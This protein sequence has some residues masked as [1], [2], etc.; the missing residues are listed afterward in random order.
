M[1]TRDLS[2]FLSDVMPYVTTCPEPTAIYHLRNAAIDFCQRTRIW[3]HEEEF[4]LTESQDEVFCVP[5]DAAIHEIE[6]A[7]FNGS[8]LQALPYGN[9]NPQTSD[10]LPHYITQASPDTVKVY[11]FHEGSL[12]LQLFL[13]PSQDAETVPGFL[14]D[15]HKLTIAYGALAEILMLPLPVANPGLAADFRQRF[16]SAVNARFRANIR[17]QQRAPARSRSNYF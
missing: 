15:H 3:R 2:D 9:V 10:A 17:G 8:R 7:W 16:E 14:Y 13:K 12:R 4:G 5:G 6:H 11:P 1:I